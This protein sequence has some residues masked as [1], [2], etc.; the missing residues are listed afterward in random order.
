MP[1]VIGLRL[2]GGGVQLRLRG[3]EPLPAGLRPAQL[4]GRLVASRIGPEPGVLVRVDRGGL[5]Q[6]RRDLSVD[7]GLGAVGGQRCWAAHLGAVDR[8]QPD[9]DHPGLR[10]HSR[11][12]SVNTAA[13]ACS[14]RARNRAI[15]V[16]S[17]TWLAVITLNAT[18]TRQARS[19]ARE[20]RTPVQ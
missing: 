16:W 1:L 20:E 11:S 7:V 12:D 9:L 13:S 2:H 8:D 4:C 19:I 15:V 6:H 17:G 10:A 3:G 18:S 14:W 5:G